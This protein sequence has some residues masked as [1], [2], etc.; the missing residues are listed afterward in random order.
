MAGTRTYAQLMDEVVLHLGNDSTLDSSTYAGLWVNQ[1]YIDLTTRFE[2]LGQEM[3]GLR[4]VFPELESN[5]QRTTTDG[6][7]YVAKPLDCTVIETVYDSENDYKLT[8]RPYKWYLRQTGHATS[9]A[10]GEPKY[11]TPYGLY[12]YFHPTPDDAYDMEIKYRRRPAL[13][14][15]TTDVTEISP[16]WDE[17]IVKLATC[18]GFYALQD[19]A[20]GKVWKDEF[21]EGIAGKLRMQNISVL[22]TKEY[23]RPDSTYLDWGY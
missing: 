11:W 7:A 20:K 13:L 8:Y 3:R 1:A 19:F 12:V 17:Y 18:K 5:Q 15:A 22:D 16:E 21:I 9:T 23:L 6:T 14:S 2:L 10:E 4:F